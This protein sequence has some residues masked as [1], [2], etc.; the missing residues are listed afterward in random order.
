MPAAWL[1]KLGREA[2]LALFFLALALVATRPLAG[3]LR[4]QTLV[5]PD[6]LIDLWTV[7]WLSGHVLS[8]G[9][10]FEGNLF[11]PHRHAVL[12]S[13]LSMGSVALV[14]PIRP[15]VTDAVALYNLALILTLAFGGW[16][17]CLLVRA[18][19]G[20]L[21]AGL[22]SGTLSAFSS[23]QL[24]HVYH[25]NL[26]GIG[27]LALLLLA[28]QRLHARPGPGPALLAAAAFALTALTSGY[29]AVAATLLALLFAA[30]HREMFSGRRLL[31]ALLAGLL[32][33]LLM[34]PYLQAFGEL[35]EDSGLRRPPGMSARMAF[36][37][38][39]D[40]GS[41]AFVHRA[42]LGHRGEV[43]F[44]GLLTLLLAPCALVRRHPQA[45][46]Y[47]G[48]TLLLLLLSLGPALSVFGLTLPL[49]YAALFALPGLD[50]MRHP[51]TF[52]A[53]AGFCASVLAGLGFSRLALAQKRWAGPLLLGLAFVETLGPA[54]HVRAVPPGVP[55]AY[56]LLEQLPPG[57]TLEVPPFL[58]EAVLWAT[59]H[60]LPVVNGIGAFAPPTTARL[61]NEIR[62]H[63]L[64]R[65]PDDVDAS[66]PQ[67]LLDDFDVRYLILDAGRRPVLR[68]LARALERSRGF[69][70]LGACDD[71][72]R[73]YLRSGGAPVGLGGASALCSTGA[74]QAHGSR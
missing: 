47:L 34:L 49:P 70:L 28:L 1:H 57:A 38:E 67:Q 66:V 14:L 31:L 7:H 22:L 35:R 5:G 48:A 37:P 29:Y 55:A 71:G 20:N 53:V 21:W 58:P 32:A 9:Q 13:D 27:W 10:F 43:L 68:R 41:R 60:G 61:E 33:L 56:R 74:A 30:F 72:S 45:G 8:P 18:Q 15:F 44:P 23:H 63:W 59:R 73:L 6:P 52:A 2:G 51:Y 69:Q 11:H 65:A 39:R 19:S 64:R 50:A 24:F 26:L 40:L 25:L 54:V 3:D 17:F 62:T 46:F 42:W 4:G 16:A 12:Y 36:V